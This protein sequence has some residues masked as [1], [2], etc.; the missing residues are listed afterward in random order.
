MCSHTNSESP[1]N[2]L[3]PFRVE[4]SSC[5]F[6]SLLCCSLNLDSPLKE[7]QGGIPFRG[8]VCGK[9]QPST[10]LVSLL[11]PT[12]DGIPPPAPY[13]DKPSRR[14]R[15]RRI[16]TRATKE[17]GYGN[18]SGTDYIRTVGPSLSCPNSK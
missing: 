12:M 1:N 9:F 8:F 13:A 18:H 10:G 14:D 15:Y 17:P 2:R 11:D 6:R 4:L 16:R 5:V 3:T 7:V